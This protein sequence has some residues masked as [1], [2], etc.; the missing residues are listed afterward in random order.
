MARY[1]I[2]S[3]ERVMDVVK[4]KSIREAVEGL[5]VEGDGEFEV[6]TVTSQRT[7]GFATVQE[8]RLTFGTDD[9]DVVDEEE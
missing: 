7:V 1:L 4:A 9:S 8:T 6:Y 2:V 3:D 5:G